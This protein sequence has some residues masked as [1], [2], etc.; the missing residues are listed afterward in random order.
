[1]AKDELQIDLES[2][3]NYFFII[4]LVLFTCVILGLELT[5]LDYRLSRNFYDATL[6]S[7]PYRHA[8]I[9]EQLIYHGGK[10]LS[11]V[12]GLGIL[13]CLLISQSPKSALH[14]Y[15][16]VLTYL[17]IAGITGPV[18]IAIMKS[19][20]H[21]YCPWDLKIFSG[22]RPYIR[23]FDYVTPDMD[24]GH[25]FP[26]G[27]AAD[28]YTLVSLYFFFLIIKPRYKYYGLAAGI[29]L[30]LIYGFAQQMRGA[31][32]LSHDLFSLAVCWYSS[33]VLF[34]LFFRK[35]LHWV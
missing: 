13:I 19:Y 14:G 17:L 12:I 18:I 23:L 26:A 31:Q 35:K 11:E 29:L 3:I 15:R 4:P 20:S 30:G 1:M 9:T 24:N 8:W 28:G 34:V 27:L 32:F 22:S 21:I 6:H 33:L 7:W 2:F 5:D 10:Y 16:R 25:C